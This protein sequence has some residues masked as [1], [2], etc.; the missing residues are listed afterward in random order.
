MN[1]LKHLLKKYCWR[2]VF[3]N[4]LFG[5]ASQQN[6]S[7][8]ALLNDSSVFSKEN[9]N[10]FT[11]DDEDGILLNIIAKTA[12]ANKTFVDIGSNDCINSNCAILAFHHNWSGVFMD[13]NKTILE[14]GKYIYSKHF[15][16][17]ANRFSF[18]DAIVTVNNI[19]N[20]LSSQLRQ[21]EIDLL[22]LDLDGNDY[23]IWEAIT[24]IN[25]KIVVV[26]VQVEKGNTDYIPDYNNA[27]EKYESDIPKG[28]SPLSMLKL[29]NK[30][31]YELIAVNKGSYNLFFVKKDF[32]GKLKPI[33]LEEALNN[34]S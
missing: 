10:I 9:L 28:A 3:R 11:S 8:I 23:F 19:N 26:E 34:N 29:A 31:G 13:G 30:K 18:V 4:K 5:K 22:S 12:C 32:M 15:G 17:S 7:F 1:Q 14:R 24:V 2:L 20:I 16:G 27:F 21:K 33:A 25:P 6:K